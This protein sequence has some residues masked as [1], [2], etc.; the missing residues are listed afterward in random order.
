[1]IF[2]AIAGT[3]LV[4]VG[5]FTLGSVVSQSYREKVDRNLLRPIR[6]YR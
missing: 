4:F 1:M 2:R 6:N 3:S 5:G